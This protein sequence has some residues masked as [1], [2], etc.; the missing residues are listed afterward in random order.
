MRHVRD[1]RIMVQV[2]RLVP[3]GHHHQDGKHMMLVPSDVNNISGPRNSPGNQGA[4]HA[5]GSW[6]VKNL[7]IG[8]LPN[9]WDVVAHY[10]T[11]DCK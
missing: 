3:A 11:D 6:V 7:G 4:P 2:W 1:V 5:G 10:L 9:P 8:K